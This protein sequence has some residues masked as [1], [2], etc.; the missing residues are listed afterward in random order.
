MLILSLNEHSLHRDAQWPPRVE[1]VRLG[2]EIMRIADEVLI[3]SKGKTAK[4][5]TVDSPHPKWTRYCHVTI[6]PGGNLVIMRMGP[7]PYEPVGRDA[8]LIEE[9]KRVLEE[10]PGGT[11][12]G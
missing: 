6:T 1:D 7:G 5:K 8:E 3:H 9:L 12:P 10:A 11:F 2:S 4:L